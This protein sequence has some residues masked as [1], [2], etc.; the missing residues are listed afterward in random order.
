MTLSPQ[1]VWYSDRP[2]VVIERM[3]P[4]RQAVIALLGEPEETLTV[5]N[6]ELVDFKHKENWFQEQ[7]MIKPSQP[8]AH[9][10]ELQFLRN[11]LNNE[12][13]LPYAISEKLPTPVERP[14]R[15]GG[16]VSNSEAYR[17]AQGY[18]MPERVE[19]EAIVDKPGNL[20]SD[21]D[22]SVDGDYLRFLMEI[23]DIS[24]NPRNLMEKLAHVDSLGENL[25]KL[26]LAIFGWENSAKIPV[27]AV[28]EISRFFDTRMTFW[29][30]TVTPEIFAA[31]QA[32]KSAISR[33]LAKT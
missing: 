26:R 19:P 32:T 5:E 4:T 8:S 1:I 15:A 16:G 18:L 33:I 29:A 2:A 10:R 21:E 24:E 3:K 23:S 22:I 14:K 20:K 7:L 31:L 9:F 30:E 11:I 27:E 13:T 17:M 6:H 25:A 12:Q 28:E